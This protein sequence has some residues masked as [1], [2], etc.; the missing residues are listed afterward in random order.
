[1][2]KEGD[3]L[4][5]QGS[6]KNLLR[7]LLFSN[8]LFQETRHQHTQKPP[9]FCANSP[10]SYNKNNFNLPKTKDKRYLSEME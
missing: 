4:R 1:M 7:A 6:I 10:I 5:R 8:L 9:I 2:D 3:Q